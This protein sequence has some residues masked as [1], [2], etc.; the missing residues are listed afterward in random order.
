MKTGAALLWT[1]VLVVPGVLST[2]PVQARDRELQSA[3]QKLGCVPSKILP[4]PLS[5]TL[6]AYE[7]TCKGSSETLYIV[8]RQSECTPQPRRRDDDDR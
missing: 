3:L 4:T 1:A 2:G 5:S 6:V 7:V 8:C